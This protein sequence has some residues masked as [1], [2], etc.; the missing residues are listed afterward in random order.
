MPATFS[1]SFTPSGTP[2][3]GRASPRRMRVAAASA[4]RNAS[5]RSSSATTAFNVPRVA[6]MRSWQ[7]RMSSTGDTWPARKTATKS[8]RESPRSFF[9]ARDGLSGELAGM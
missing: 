7:A 9:T 2:S 5:S 6:S 3:K 8:M 1:K 4:A